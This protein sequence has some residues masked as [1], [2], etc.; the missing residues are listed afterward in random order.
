MP[1]PETY[2]LINGVK[3]DWSS[4]SI[5]I[6]TLPLP[7]PIGIK[8]ISYKWDRTP[9]IVHGIGHAQPIARTRGRFKFEGSLEIYTYDDANL[10]AALA[11]SVPNPDPSLGPQGIGE[12]VFDI[13]V[14]YRDYGEAL[15]TDDLIGCSI[16]GGEAGLS[17]SD[18]P[19][20]KKR[21]L[22]LMMILENGIPVVSNILP[23]TLPGPT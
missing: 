15:T 21:P 6:G 11:S 19:T 14:S 5:A 23:G 18:D 20:T 4:I 1:P 10:M 16:I 8:A 2:P 12:W 22:S 3:Y 7:G 13:Q 17:E 9:G